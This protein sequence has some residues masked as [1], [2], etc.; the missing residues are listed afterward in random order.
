MGESLVCH[1]TYQILESG[2][3]QSPSFP[4][5]Q[6]FSHNTCI[7]SRRLPKTQLRINMTLAY[8]IKIPKALPLSCGYSFLLIWMETYS[9]AGRLWNKPESI[10]ELQIIL[11]DAKQ[12]LRKTETYI[13]FSGHLLSRYKIFTDLENT[14]T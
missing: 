6:R 1:I 10:V 7:L 14:I 5:T 11:I 13:R 8:G 3:T 2:W 4:V 9:Y 12:L